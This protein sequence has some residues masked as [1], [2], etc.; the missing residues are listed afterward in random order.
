MRGQHFRTALARATIR[1]GSAAT[2]E[3]VSR[4]MPLGYDAPALKFTKAVRKNVDFNDYPYVT[5][6]HIRLAAL[7]GTQTVE[8]V[9]NERTIGSDEDRPVKLPIHNES[10]VNQ[11]A[12]GKAYHKN[13]TR[14]LS[15]VNQL[16]ER[17]FPY[18]VGV[19]EE[20]DTY[21]G[22]QDGGWWYNTGQLV[23]ESKPFMTKRGALKEERRLK[24]QYPRKGR[25]ILS[26]RANDA[27]QADED[28]GVFEPV[29]YTDN[30]AEVLGMPSKFIQEPEDEDYDY[31]VFGQPSEDYRTH[32]TRGKPDQHYPA[33][34]PYYL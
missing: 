22:E 32:I 30:A 14:S 18:R 26:V 6:K 24:Q 1:P 19:Y 4:L 31:S 28:R 12:L 29:E 17:L 3:Q 23:H 27:F 2:G 8:N 9:L 34:K 16:K 5:K 33:N 25:N 13:Q 7:L 15:R 10:S 20:H 11:V 21:G